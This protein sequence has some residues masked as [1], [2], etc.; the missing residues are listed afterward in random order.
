MGSFSYDGSG[1]RVRVLTGNDLALQ[2][3]HA[4]PASTEGNFSI[5]LLSA[6]Y[7]PNGLCYSSIADLWRNALIE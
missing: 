7:Y 6:A 2:F 5:N 1:E 3:S 4:L